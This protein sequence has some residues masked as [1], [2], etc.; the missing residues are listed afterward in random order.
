MDAEEFSDWEAFYAVEVR[1]RE[2]K[3]VPT[4]DVGEIGRF[5]AQN[6]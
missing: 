2:G 1:E 4:T 5:F 3:P 6:K